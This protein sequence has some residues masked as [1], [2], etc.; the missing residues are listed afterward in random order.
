MYFLQICL[1]P[2]LSSHPVGSWGYRWLHLP[3][4]P[5]QDQD[6]GKSLKAL[7]NQIPGL[8]APLTSGNMK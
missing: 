1:I 2:V 3:P 5:R 4:G 8:S 7:V 6:L